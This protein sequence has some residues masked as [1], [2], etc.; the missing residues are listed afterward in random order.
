M[1]A[2][3]GFAKADGGNDPTVKITVPADAPTCPSSDPSVVCFTSTS[4][5]DPIIIAGTG[6][7]ISDVTTDFIY[8]CDPSSPSCT[9]LDNVFLAIDPTILGDTYSISIGAIDG[10]EPAFNTYMTGVCYNAGDESYDLLVDLECVS[11]TSLPECTGMTGG[12]VGAAEVAPEPS[13]LLLLG[14]GI[15]LVGLYG[16]KRRKVFVL[17]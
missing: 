17:S 16:R 14:I 9:P 2:G 4:S 11:S 6:G 13:D 12:E 1:I 5:T 15:L 8:D 3:A 10:S 7:T